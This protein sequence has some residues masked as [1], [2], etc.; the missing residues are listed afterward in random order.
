MQP[1]LV[2]LTTVNNP[3]HAL[4]LRALLDA[5]G[6]EAKLRGEALGPYRL[7]VGAMAA[8]EIWIR[9]DRLEEARMVLLAADVDAAVADVEPF[10]SGPSAHPLRSWMWWIVAA[11]LIG[12]VIYG[13]VLIVGG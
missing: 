2:H 12:V 9:S 8:T 1:D 5:E 6:I 13:R 11:I 3:N 4:V 10:G 7:T